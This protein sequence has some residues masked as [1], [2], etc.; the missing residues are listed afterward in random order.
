MDRETL[1][2]IISIFIDYISVCKPDSFDT[3]L[4]EFCTYEEIQLIKKLYEEAN[5]DED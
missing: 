2:N 3:Y 4:S 1:E 5:G